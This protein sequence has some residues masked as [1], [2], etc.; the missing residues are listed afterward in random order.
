MNPAHRRNLCQAFIR[1]LRDHPKGTL[2]ADQH[3][4]WL[5]NAVTSS[6]GSG[7]PAG[8]IIA[9]NDLAI[10]PIRKIILEGVCRLSVE[11]TVSQ[12]L[13][14]SIFLRILNEIKSEISSHSPETLFTFG[15]AQ[16][17]ITIYMKTLYAAFWGEF[18]DTGEDIQALSWL[19]R[20]SACLHIPVD[21][22]TIEYFDKDP[23]NRHLT[24]IGP[25]LVSWKWD[26]EQP[27][28]ESLQALARQH[29]AAGNYLDPMHFEMDRIWT[30][31]GGNSG[32][33]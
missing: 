18:R 31:P 2:R 3:E 20:W 14:D 33:T 17:L 4:T 27:A 16:N 19:G 8:S 21:R 12:Q 26:L 29:A 22:G 9:L 7:N 28:Y 10:E 24:R 13:F 6:G 11:A 25:K 15:R 5:P 1:Y 30:Q 23:T 32:K